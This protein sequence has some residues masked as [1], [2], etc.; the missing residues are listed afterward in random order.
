MNPTR[1]RYRRRAIGPAARLTPPSA[2]LARPVAG[3]GIEPG[4]DL[5]RV[6]RRLAA[7]NKQPHESHERSLQTRFEWVVGFEPTDSIVEIERHQF[8][9]SCRWVRLPEHPAGLE[10]AHPGWKPGALPLRHER[11]RPVA[12]QG[13]E[14]SYRT[15]EARPAPRRLQF[16]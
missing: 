3:P 13:I 2:Q 8:V 6:S 14:P 15:Y 12:G 7:C 10:P 11:F 4:A 1:V 16:E 5:M 9:S